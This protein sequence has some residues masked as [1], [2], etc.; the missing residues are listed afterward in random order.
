MPARNRALCDFL[1]FEIFMLL[2]DLMDPVVDHDEIVG[3]HSALRFDTSCLLD[4]LL[5]QYL[6]ELTREP[7]RMLTGA[8]TTRGR[9]GRRRSCRGRVTTIPRMIR[10][11]RRNLRAVIDSGRTHC[12]PPAHT[13]TATGTTIH[14]VTS[15]GR[16]TGTS[17]SALTDDSATTRTEEG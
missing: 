12:P 8:A 3:I 6:G 7:P 11:P 16:S 14:S 5:F 13:T 10:L 15:R 1:E 17:I 4:L 9:R 2:L